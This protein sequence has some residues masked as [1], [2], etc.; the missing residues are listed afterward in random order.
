MWLGDTGSS[1][2]RNYTAL[3]DYYLAALS[4]LVGG[5]PVVTYAHVVADKNRDHI[6][7]QYWFFY[8]Y[9]DWFN[10]HEGD[11]EMIQVMLDRTGQ[12]EWAV[13]SQHQGG[14]RRRWRDVAVEDGTHPVVYVAR[15]PTPT[16]SGETSCFPTAGSW[17]TP[18][19]RCWIAPAGR[20]ASCLR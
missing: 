19:L 2:A 20:A 9:N 12:P 1:D 16:T 7:I 18:R 11:W 15:A 17:A 3:R 8:F 13:Y 4:P 14:T 6:T 10:K 5:P